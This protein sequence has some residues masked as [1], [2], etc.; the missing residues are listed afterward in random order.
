MKF[1][2]DREP[3]RARIVRVRPPLVCMLAASLIVIAAATL[4][5]YGILSLVADILR[6]L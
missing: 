4:G 6:A 2:F 5:L 3:P 1:T